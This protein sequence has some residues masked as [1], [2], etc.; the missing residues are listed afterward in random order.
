ML[1]TIMEKWKV[2]KKKKKLLKLKLCIQH[3][4]QTPFTQIVNR[5]KH[6]HETINTVSGVWNDI[7]T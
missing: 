3:E 2:C 1:K 6:E 7:N 5:K 4:F